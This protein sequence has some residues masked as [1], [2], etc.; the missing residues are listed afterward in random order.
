MRSRLALSAASLLL[1]CASSAPITTWPYSSWVEKYGAG[2]LGDFKRVREGCLAQLGIAEPASVAQDSP[3]EDQFL[4][5]MNAAGW[6]TERYGCE[7]PGA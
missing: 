2:S 6:C 1:A 5:C 3:T 7:K 4:Q